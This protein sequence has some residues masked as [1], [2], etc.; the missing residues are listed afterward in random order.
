MNCDCLE[1]LLNELRVVQGRSWDDTGLCF[2]HLTQALRSALRPQDSSML[3]RNCFLPG[4]DSLAERKRWI[5][6]LYTLS[7]ESKAFH[8]QNPPW[9]TASQDQ[10]TGDSNG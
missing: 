9:L 2:G 6:W 10:T 8:E 4:P 5:D 3:T 1:K 7:P